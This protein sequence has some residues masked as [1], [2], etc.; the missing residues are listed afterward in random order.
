LNELLQELPTLPQI[1][2]IS[3]T[4]I[5]KSPLINISLLNYTF[6]HADSTTSAGGVGINIAYDLP[7]SLIGFMG[8][9]KTQMDAKYNILL[10]HF[11]L[12]TFLYIM[13]Y[14]YIILFVHHYTFY[15]YIMSYFSH[16]II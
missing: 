7:F 6:L 14:L 15:L 5:K 12:C 9:T 2:G 8:S 4:R 1:I 3:E 13:S 11:Q 10:C 16:L